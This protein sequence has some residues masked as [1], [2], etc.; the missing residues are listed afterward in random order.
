MLNDLIRSA[1]G[2]HKSAERAAFFAKKSIE[3]KQKAVKVI[4]STRIADRFARRL[5][6]FEAGEIIVK[7]YREKIDATSGDLTTLKFEVN[8]RNL[9][10]QGYGEIDGESRNLKLTQSG[11]EWLRPFGETTCILTGRKTSGKF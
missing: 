6:G 11:F 7:N 10:R 9:I 1:G 4:A 8:L 5:A 2:I 3:D